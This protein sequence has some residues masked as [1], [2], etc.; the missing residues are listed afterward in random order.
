[1][2]G[3]VAADGPRPRGQPAEGPLGA[4]ARGHGPCRAHHRR[5]RTGQ[6]AAGAHDQAARLGAGRSTGRDPLDVGRRLSA[7]HPAVISWRCT[8][9]YQNSGLHPVVDFLERSVGSGREQP[10][11]ARLE[12]LLRYLA[13]YGLDRPDIVPLFASLL[14]LPLDERFSPLGLPPI[15]ERE[16]TFRAISEWVRTASERRPV[17]FVVEDLHWID[18]STLEFLRQF[19]AEG[20]HDRILML[21]TF[22]PEFQTPWPAL[23][24]Q[25]TLA[26]NRLTR[27]QV[28]ELMRQKMRGVPPDA[29]IEQI[30][31]RTN[32]VPLFVEEFTKLV[33]ESGVLDQ[34]GHDST[35][36]RALVARE[37]PA[38]LQDL[39]TARLDRW[40]GDREV[41]QL[42]A[43][44][45]RDFSYDLLA[46][47][48][49][50]DEATLQAELGKLVQGEI[51]YPKGRPPRCSYI[52]KHAL[53]E[54]ALYNAL[55]TGKR[56]E[57][58]R[59]IA[60]AIE[61][62]L[63]PTGATQPELLARH[64]TEAGMIEQA[65][66]YWLQAGLRS[67]ARSAEL[68]A[69]GHLTRGLELLE[70][71]DES[72]ARD[73]RQLE[74]LGP[75]GVAYLAVRGYAA[76]EVGPVFRRARAVRAKRAAN[77]ALRAF[78]R[79]LGV[80]HGAR[81]SPALYR[82]GRRRDGVCRPAERP[83]HHDGSALHVR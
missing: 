63:P 17:L 80:A 10:K 13:E 14:S 27:R 62:R 74:L 3:A 34:A 73:A 55:V 26:L 79:H 50:V 66:G 81:R 16:E 19:L 53:L 72:P 42:A 24:H 54:D 20:L 36:L 23:A 40:E 22:R 58:H 70:A 12:R 9:H 60:E 77:R 76:P 48:V 75:L 28:G 4:G 56:R 38:T 45:G 7:D 57:F 61:T 69:I 25:T 47:V 11:V 6:V 41:A 52:F 59:R 44:L 32:G 82:A 83:R 71:L 21:L 29:V 43:V 31:E 2:R 35:R 67:R 37:I 64:Y 1:M 18:A 46:A 30:Y 39:V 78:A 8:P 49:T 51:L 68:E 5:G 33:Q 15:R 65:V